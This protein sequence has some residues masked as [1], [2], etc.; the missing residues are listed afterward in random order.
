MLSRQM[1]NKAL[2]MEEYKA[3]TKL[4]PDMANQLLGIIN[5]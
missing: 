3:L 4:N 1:G 2:A 5:K